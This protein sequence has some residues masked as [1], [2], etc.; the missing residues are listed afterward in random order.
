MSY[1]ILRKVKEKSILMD[2]LELNYIISF[3]KHI[4]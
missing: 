4:M 1:A 2:I 3:S